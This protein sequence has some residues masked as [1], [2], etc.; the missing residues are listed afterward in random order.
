MVGSHPHKKICKLCQKEYIATSNRQKYCKSCSKNYHQ[1]YYQENKKTLVKQ[2]QKW[3]LNNKEKTKQYV[4]EWRKKNPEKHHEYMI[5]RYHNDDIFRKKFKEYMKEY[6]IKRYHN[7]D[8]FRKNLLK[9][10]RKRIK[11][12]R[13]DKEY[14]AYEAGLRRKKGFIKIL[15]NIFPDNIQIEYHHVY[16]NLPFV[17]PLPTNCHQI[18]IGEHEDYLKNHVENGKEWIDFF[19]NINIDNFLFSK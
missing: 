13:K 19:Y 2:H 10:Q 5:K 3:R 12:K 15:P 9:K 17:V 11:E 4:Y 7:D 14:R 8:I 1:K 18:F 16:T 6:M